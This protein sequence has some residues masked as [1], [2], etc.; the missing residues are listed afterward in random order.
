MR[1]GP[2]F[3]DDFFRPDGDGPKSLH[4]Q[5]RRHV[6]QRNGFDPTRPRRPS[7]GQHCQHHVPRARGIENL[8]RPGMLQPS[9]LPIPRRQVSA[10]A[11]QRDDRRLQI[12]HREQLFRRRPILIRS[13][14]INSR[15]S[16]GLR[17]IQL[18][19]RRAAVL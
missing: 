14:Q 8:T 11:I 1:L 4:L 12:E 15:C 16:S 13:V 3:L 6:S 10:V 18:Y 2:Q 19:R 5:A 7:R 9:P 17:A